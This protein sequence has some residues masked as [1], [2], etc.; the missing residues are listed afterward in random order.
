MSRAPLASA[1]APAR[2]AARRRARWVMPLVGTLVGAL[3]VVVLGLAT[4]WWMYTTSSGLQFLVLLN[5]RLNSA[6]VLRD[7]SGSLRDGFTAGSLTIKGPTWSLRATDLAVEPHE[8][9]LRQRVFDFQ[10]LAAGTVTSTGSRVRTGKARL[11]CAAY[12]S[13]SA[14]SH[15]QRPSLR[16]ARR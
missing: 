6:L 16:R 12:R 10:R 8:V 13:T 1:D 15:R 7:V 5:S 14:Q 4:M 2:A 9:Q 3:L 11:A